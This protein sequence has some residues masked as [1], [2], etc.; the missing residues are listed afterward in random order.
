MR[1]ELKGLE[2][3]E[4]GPLEW[5]AEAIALVD[6][7]EEVGEAEAEE[8]VSDLAVAIEIL[9]VLVVEEPLPGAEARTKR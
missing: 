1:W 2:E 8:P 9:E 3:V 4:V 7:V 5:K 6:Q